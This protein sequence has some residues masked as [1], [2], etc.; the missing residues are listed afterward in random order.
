MVELVFV[1]LVSAAVVLLVSV[2]CL[3]LVDKSREHVSKVEEETRRLLTARVT[4]LENRLL[5]HSWTDY[6]NLQHTP[7]EL[8][9]SD[10]EGDGRT[11]ESYGELYEDRVETWLRNQGADLEGDTVQGPVVG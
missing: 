6:A 7:N 10:T 2:T 5:S 4:T 1:I 3:Q 9:L 8:N 11:P